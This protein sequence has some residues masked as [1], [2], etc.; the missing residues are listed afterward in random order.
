VISAL[1]VLISALSFAFYMGLAA[2]GL[3][4]FDGGELALAAGT[5]GVAH[6]PGE[7]AYLVL[8][9]LAALLPIGDLSFRLTLLSAITVSLSAGIASAIGLRLVAMAGLAASGS[10]LGLLVA[11]GLVAFAPAAV[12]QAVRPELYGLSLLLGLGAL[13]ALLLA[14]RRGPAL[15]VLALCIAGAV[16]YAL[17]VA[18]LPGLAWLAWRYG[19][20]GLRF[21]VGTAG[22]LL[23]P[24]L[25]QYLWLP[26]RSQRGPVL[27]FG[28]AQ[29]W[30][31]LWWVVSAGPYRRSFDL[32]DGQLLANARGHLS[33][34]IE[35]LGLFAL[36]LVLVGLLKLFR[37]APGAALAGVLLVVGGALPTLLQGVFRLD[38]PDLWG[39][40]LLPLAV[41]GCIAAVG[42]AALMHVLRG[43]M[44]WLPS[45][46]DVVLCL[47]VLLGPALS[48]LRSADYSHRSVPARLANTVLD[49]SPP[50][51]LL[52]LSGDSWVFP[53]LYQR[54]WEGRRADVEI[55]P[56]LQLSQASL[57][58]LS[59]RGVNLPRNLSLEQQ[60]W[61]ASTPSTVRQEQVLR[62]LVAGVRDR[63]VLVNEA[64]LPPELEQRKSAQGLLYR[65]S[66]QVESA[67]APV[68]GMSEQ[69]DILWRQ[70]LAP[71]AA[72]AGFA[73]DRTAHGVLSRRFSARAGFYR[74]RGR[75]AAAGLALE[76][77]SQLAP[78][79]SDLIHLAGYRFRQGLDGVAGVLG[80]PTQFSGPWMDAFAIADDIA[81][82]RL[83]DVAIANASDLDSALDLHALRGAART[84]TGDLAEA[85][86][87]LEVVLEERPLHPQA[88]LLQ[89]RLYSLGYQVTRRRP[90]TGPA[91]DD[92]SSGGAGG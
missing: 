10:T 64:F 22:V 85:A 76:R 80:V 77:G 81:A 14:G 21:G 41:L 11:G 91:S 50:G 32:A 78:R 44:S 49:G 39:Y 35:S 30:E 51:G 88:T 46:L 74:S 36:V 31:N 1:P 40:L 56:L 48:S 63:P 75:P 61:L 28:N 4:W 13:A 62:L 2:P 52:L 55:A 29:S 65:L 90:L 17:L 9:R 83:L 70:A 89:E 45:S 67:G 27:D 7:P 37:R 20:S 12:L 66:S 47:A 69:E 54:Y 18:A 33:L 79:A 87:D 24:G 59:D 8:A 57:A 86:E 82:A 6:P 73:L 38:N 92:A 68:P 26:L 5:M 25:L 19:R 34:V 42:A 84:L 58:A 16:H 15:A 72:D 60:T 71:I 23:V 3:T 43:W 53:A